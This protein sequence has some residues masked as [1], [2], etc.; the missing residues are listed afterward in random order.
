L[1]QDSSV[2]GKTG[3]NHSLGKNLIGAFHQPDAVI[4]DV[5][6]LQTLPEKEWRSGFAEMIKHGFIHDEELLHELKTA[7]KQPEQI[8]ETELIPLLKKSIQVKAEIVQ[9]DEKEYG[10]RAFLNFGHTLGHALEKHA[11]YG[12][13]TH[14][15]GVV[16]GMVF[17]LEV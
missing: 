14:G 16:C 6:M 17:A 7:I 13:L 3:I 2:G 1:A 12:E 4:Y 9:L 11:G 10:A 8:K 5:E 15:E